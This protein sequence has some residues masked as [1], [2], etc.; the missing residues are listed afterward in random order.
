MAVSA[1]LPTTFRTAK[2]RVSQA[3][4]LPAPLQGMDARVPLAVDSAQ[5]CIWA[6]NLLPTEYSL[7]VRKG[8]REWQTNVDSGE[9][10]RTIL[11]YT[12]SAAS[13]SSDKL[14]AVTKNG[15]YDVSA[16]GGSPSLKVSFSSNTADAGYGTFT[17]YVDESGDDMMFYADGDNGL[18]K[19]DPTGDT[20][21]QHT[22]ITADAAAI[23][24][25]DMTAVNFIMVHKLRI[26]M[27]EK[28]QNFAW[29]LPIRSATGAVKEFF[30]G[31]KFRHGGELVGLYNWTV[32]GG[33]GRDD[34]LVAISRGGDVIPYTG[35]D[36]AD[37]TTWANTGTFFIGPVPKGSRVASEYGGELFVLS[38]FG[39]TAMSSLLRGATLQ[40]PFTNVI[41][42]KIARLLR[43]DLSLQGDDYGWS[44][45]VVADVGSIM[46]TAP[47][48]ID[49][50]GYRQYVYNIATQGWGLWRD[51]PILSSDSWTGALM[52]GTVDGKV[53]RMNANKDEVA[54]A[55]TGG[56]AIEWFLLTSYSHLGSPA[57]FKRSKLARPNFVAETEPLYKISAHYDYQTDEPAQ[58]TGTPESGSG[59][60]WDVGL[61]GTALWSSGVNTPYNDIL[62]QS[63][64]G[65]SVAIALVGES[66]TECDLASFDLVWDVGGVM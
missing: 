53:Y 7:R 2:Q 20:W 48:R 36:P 31:S 54:A 39:I 18:F 51:V 61:W 14:F 65:R 24:T 57:Q 44:I 30:F 43:A 38:K 10:V 27:V 35:E 1:S 34:H 26:W 25:F 22:G 62:G 37:V 8:T 56:V 66:V 45:Q 58:V 47:E 9:E 29:Y 52:V 32:D 16:S 60:V 6:I 41:G 46:I 21:A 63:G 50:T 5:T 49:G 64:I 11:P 28:D 13:G 42:H 15:I 23:N 19:Y 59:D 12:G 3:T 4:V 17:Q 40:D 55:G 33:Y